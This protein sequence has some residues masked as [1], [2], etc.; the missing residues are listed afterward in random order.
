MKSIRGRLKQRLQRSSSE[1]GFTLVEMVIAIPISILMLGLVFSTI[2]VAVGL[3][4]QVQA[5]AAA[6]RV[7]NSTMDQLANPRTCAEIDRIVAQRK[8]ANAT[9]AYEM[10]FSS[11][12]CEKSKRFPV[13]IEVKDKETGKLYFS[14][15]VN[16]VAM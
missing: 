5:T 2:G 13:I 3:L 9:E 4:G 16:L 10:S 6:S 7:V 8:A 12:S 1:D 15:M 14:Q 11:Y